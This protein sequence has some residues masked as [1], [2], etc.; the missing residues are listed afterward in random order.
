MKLGDASQISVGVQDLNASL[1]HYERLGFK[2]LA[3][4]TKPYPW[5]QLTDESLLLLLNQDGMKYI[6]LLYFSAKFELV[7]AD[8]KNH[9]VSFD[10]E[11]KRDD[12]LQQVFFS[13][14]DGFLI[15]IVNN[16]AKGMYQPQGPNYLTMSDAQQRDTA[17]Y[18]NNR[19]GFFG[20]FCHQVKDFKASRKFWEM[21]GFECT[22]ESGGPYHWGLFKDSWHI[23]G[24]HQTS[25][26]DYAAITYFAKDTGERIKAL[27]EHGV[28]DITPFTGTG[29]N[30]NNVVITGPEGQKVFLFSF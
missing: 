10:H 24:L 28:T 3:T 23:I 7:V 29:G 12:V 17:N 25:D 13:S 20:E 8:L 9:G 6:G 15:S 22:Y 27:R 21:L 16:D 26:F 30:E 1:A 2:V 5:A 11:L 4:G 14:P 19:L 18:P